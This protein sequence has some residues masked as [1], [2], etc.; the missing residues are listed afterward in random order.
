MPKPRNYGITERERAI[1]QLLW[2]HTE[3]TLEEVSKI[4]NIAPSTLKT[5]TNFLHQKL[6]ANCRADLLKKAIQAGHI[7]INSAS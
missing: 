7:N 3:K 6:Q 4:L 5:Y 1:L 2:D